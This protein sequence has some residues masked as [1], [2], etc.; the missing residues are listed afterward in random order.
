LPGDLDAERDEA[1][2]E[3]AGGAVICADEGVGLE[4]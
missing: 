2:H 4:G 1:V 3:M